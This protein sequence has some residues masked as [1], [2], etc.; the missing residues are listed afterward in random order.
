VEENIEN[1]QELS[2]AHA[3]HLYRIVQEAVNNA[4]KHSRATRIQVKI[5]AHESWDVVISDDGRGFDAQHA[6]RG[7]GLANM[8]NRSNEAGWNIAWTTN[9]EGGT[10]VRVSTTN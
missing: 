9:E 3:F 10:T 2:S 4:L 7:N 5:D 8:K 1:D 6:G